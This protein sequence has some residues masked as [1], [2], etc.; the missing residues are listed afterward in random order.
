MRRCQT[1]GAGRGLSRKR[2]G[3]V[4]VGMG[5]GVRARRRGC[6]GLQASR[7]IV[8]LR[9][10]ILSSICTSATSLSLLDV[11]LSSTLVRTASISGFHKVVPPKRITVRTTSTVARSVCGGWTLT[12][13]RKLRSSTPPLHLGHTCDQNTTGIPAPVIK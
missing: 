4:E 10:R 5:M 2:D 12:G 3:K 9:L 11:S 8:S 6:R 7:S 13:R 1:W